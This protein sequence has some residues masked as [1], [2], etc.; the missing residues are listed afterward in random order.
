ML[1]KERNIP[2]II[3]ELI[4]CGIDIYQVHVEEPSLEEIFLQKN[5]VDH[6]QV[7]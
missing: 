6:S 2:L 3:R 4:Q 5:V 7:S 1:Q